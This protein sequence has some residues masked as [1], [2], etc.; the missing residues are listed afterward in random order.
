VNRRVSRRIH[1]YGVALPICQQCLK[2]C[3]RN[4]IALILERKK[5]IL[6]GRRLL[7]CPNCRKSFCDAELKAASKNEKNKFS[8]GFIKW[9]EKPEFF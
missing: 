7:L 4:Q 2:K 1:E 5:S 9:N 8:D 3:K 6:T